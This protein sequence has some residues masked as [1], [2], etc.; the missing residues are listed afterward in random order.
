[1]SVPA[2]NGVSPASAPSAFQAVR[3]NLELAMVNGELHHLVVAGLSPALRTE[4]IVLGLG[5]AFAQ[6]GMEV[7][8][9]DAD[10]QHPVIHAD[11]GV[12]LEPGFY[13]WVQSPE[14]EIPRQA[15]GTKDVSVLAAGGSGLDPLHSL[16]IPRIERAMKTLQE[17]ALLVIWHVPPLQS[18]VAG[19]LIAAQADATLLAVRQG[20]DRR[21]KGRQAKRRLVQAKVNV[22]GVV[23]CCQNGPTRK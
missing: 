9:I 21:S 6:V 11:A 17:E 8:L 22:V 5:H 7:L 19:D 3:A 18:S 23:A 14:K 13:Q 20:R 1:M 10:C 4:R 16:S 12:E 15:T 2:G